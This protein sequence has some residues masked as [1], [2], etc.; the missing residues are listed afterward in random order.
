MQDLVNR[1][2]KSI[3]LT[4]GTLSPIDSFTSQ[5]QMSVTL[6]HTVLNFFACVC[7]IIIIFMML[8]IT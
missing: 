1:G 6:I 5:M 7:H 3:I 4:S 2:V 8:C